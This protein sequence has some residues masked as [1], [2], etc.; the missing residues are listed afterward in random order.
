LFALAKPIATSWT[1]TLSPVGGSNVSGTATVDVPDAGMAK[2][3]QAPPAGAYDSA[4]KAAPSP[5][6]GT[7]KASITISAKEGEY[8]WHV[9]SGKC[10]S[11]GPPVGGMSAYTPIK[12]SADGK[13]TAQANI[14]FKP[15]PGTDYSVN[16]HK[17]K[18]DMA[19]ISCGDL[20][21]GGE[22][23]QNKPPRDTTAP[24]P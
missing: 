16:V 23:M 7:A 6:G 21:G 9:H 2:P 12:V 22:P 13:G 20:K 5:A 11:G 8:P 18:S 17:S 3:D 10:G 19:I 14:N 15:A 4:K 24:K 1:A